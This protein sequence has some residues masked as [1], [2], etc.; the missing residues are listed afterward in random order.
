M[1][2]RRT[3]ETNPLEQVANQWNLG[4]ALKDTPTGLGNAPKDIPASSGTL[5][6]PGSAPP[7][8]HRARSTSAPKRGGRK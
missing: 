5:R 4:N 1:T 8:A 7:S 3:P 2:N 6:K